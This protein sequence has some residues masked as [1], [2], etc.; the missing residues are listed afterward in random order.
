MLKWAM[1]II[2]DPSCTAGPWAQTWHFAAVQAQ[3][4][5]RPSGSSGHPDQHSSSR[6]MVPREPAWFQVADQTASIYRALTGNWSHRY[7]PSLCKALNP[8]TQTW[9]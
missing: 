2:T 8:E 5:S 9:S 1:D 3:I 6:S 7:Y 4:P